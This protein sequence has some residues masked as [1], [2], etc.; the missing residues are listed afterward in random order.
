[1]GSLREAARDRDWRGG[2]PFVDLGSATNACQEK[3]RVAGSPGLTPCTEKQI[4]AGTWLYDADKTGQVFSPLQRY[5]SA[6]RTVD[7]G[8]CNSVA[9][10][11]ETLVSFYTGGVFACLPVVN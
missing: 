7:K 6:G 3:N 4:R 2:L 8:I 1:M 9:Y 11:S 5:A 10:R